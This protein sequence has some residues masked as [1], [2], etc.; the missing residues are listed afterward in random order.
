MRQDEILRPDRGG[1]VGEVL[2]KVLEATDEVRQELS[3]RT[4]ELPMLRAEVDVGLII[5]RRAN[6]LDE[7]IEGHALIEMTAPGRR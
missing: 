3:L 7:L 5:G 1:Y 2:S 4:A 6:Y